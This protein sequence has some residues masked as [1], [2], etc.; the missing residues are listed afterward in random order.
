MVHV[1]SKVP[2]LMLG[3]VIALCSLMEPE[4]ALLRHLEYCTCMVCRV[5]EGKASLSAP[6]GNGFS[7]RLTYR[8]CCLW[9]LVFILIHLH[10][11]AMSM[12]TSTNS[13]DSSPSAR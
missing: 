13:S 11:V 9:L 8:S 6:S 4:V 3:Y 12:C 10:S 2:R 1:G 5:G 7:D